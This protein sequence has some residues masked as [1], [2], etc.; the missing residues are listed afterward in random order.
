MNALREGSATPDL[1]PDLRGFGNLEGRGEMEEEAS[2][3][4]RSNTR[5]VGDLGL[6]ISF[7]KEV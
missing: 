6:F 5:S 2:R 1:P 4:Q 7:L 3:I